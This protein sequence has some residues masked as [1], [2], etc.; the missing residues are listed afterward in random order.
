M[1]I[2]NVHGLRGPWVAIVEDKKWLLFYINVDNGAHFWALHSKVLSM[3]RLRNICAS[4][5]CC[6]QWPIYSSADLWPDPCQD[7]FNGWGGRWPPANLTAEISSVINMGWRQRQPFFAPPQ[8]N[9]LDH[10]H[11]PFLRVYLEMHGFNRILSQFPQ[12]VNP[13]TL[14]LLPV[15][16]NSCGLNQVCH[17]T[18]AEAEYCDEILT[19]LLK[20][21]WDDMAAM[22]PQH[23]SA[24][25]SIYCN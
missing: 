9:C 10:S 6:R 14:M 3:T 22:W 19:T 5:D 23:T 24:L 18:S 4:A 12:Q 7:L 15:V 16:L 17:K 21:P 20:H 2:Q 13:V 8:H 1:L 11:L 25:V